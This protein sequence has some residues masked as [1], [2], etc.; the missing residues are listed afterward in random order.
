MAKDSLETNPITKKLEPGS[1]EAEQSSWVPGPY[2]SAPGHPFPEVSCFVRS[3]VSSSNSILSGRQE[4]TL[5]PWKGSPFLQNQVG[6]QCICLTRVTHPCSVLGHSLVSKSL[7]LV[8]VLLLPKD[9]PV[10]VRF[11]QPGTCPS[12]SGH[13]YTLT[14]LHSPAVFFCFLQL[15]FLVP[16]VHLSK[17]S[18]VFMVGTGEPRGQSR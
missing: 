1:H 7:H 8:L 13:S 11:P 4:P 14:P 12:P 16:P 17:T 15:A 18:S 5:R 3:C 10:P 9:A 6:S 2:C